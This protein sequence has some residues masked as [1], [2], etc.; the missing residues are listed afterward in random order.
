MRKAFYILLCCAAMI[1]G[2]SL[3][4]QSALDSLGLV[5]ADSSLIFLTDLKKEKA[6][7]LIFTSNHCIYSKKYEDRLVTLITEY[8][9]KGVSF[10][11]INSNSPELS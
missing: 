9:A 8:Q 3:K 7:A 2:N 5:K 1:G 10:L 4:G 6:V 11:M